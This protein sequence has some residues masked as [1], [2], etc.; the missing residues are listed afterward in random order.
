MAQTIKPVQHPSQLPSFLAPSS[1]DTPSSQVR[2][3]L[4]PI[5]SIL[6]NEIPTI[7][8]E[9]MEIVETLTALKVYIQLNIPKIE[10]GNNFGVGVQE[11][12]VSEVG[13][14][15][16]AAFA[17]FDGIAKYFI[18]RAKCVSKL[19]KH[20]QIDDYRQ[21][22]RELDEK[23]HVDLKQYLLDLRNSYLTCHDL[24]LKNEEKIKKPKGDAFHMM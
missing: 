24:I 20:P 23:A 22:I 2:P 12:A 8:S 4:V 1:G 16:D 6:A 3:E 19:L 18:N 5:N 15:E 11:E 17:I 10:E 21:S 9:V 14:A 7:K 13:R